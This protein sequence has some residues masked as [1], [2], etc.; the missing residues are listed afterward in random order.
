MCLWAYQAILH[1]THVESPQENGKHTLK[2]LK[3]SPAVI[4]K[5]TALMVHLVT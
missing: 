3:G 2:A 4:T 1:F 5:E